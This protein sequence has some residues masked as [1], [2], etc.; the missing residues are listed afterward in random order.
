MWFGSTEW[1]C[2]FDGEGYT[3]FTEEDGACFKDSRIQE[4]KSGIVWIQSGKHLASFEGVQFSFLTL[5]QQMATDEW[6][7][8]ED[9]LWFHRGYERDGEWTGRPGAFRL[10][11]G[12]FAYLNFPVPEGD[13]SH[14]LY[15]V[16]SGPRLGKDQTLWFGSMEALIG[17][18]EGEFTFIGREEMGRA[19]DHRNV[20]IRGIFEDS[21][22]RIWMA[23]NGAGLFIYDG[24][25]T[26]N[27]TKMHGLDKGDKEGNTLHRTF[28]V[29][30]DSDGNMWFGTVYSGIWK[31]DGSSFE[32]FA[33][34]EGVP[35]ENIWTIYKTKK[36]ELLFAGE[37]P[38]AVYRY[39]GTSFDRI[40]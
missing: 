24:D 11:D 5:S 18:K 1:T 28:S 19:D 9:D 29:S 22:G 25:T 23:D 10:R 20:G 21:H 26:I 39:N 37:K 36:G 35:S 13:H 38:G 33:A 34:N 7:V 17:Y 8:A 31:F 27:F 6:D 16:S 3:Y 32:N 30:E 2:R 4:D 14:Q 40:H 15:L 12:E